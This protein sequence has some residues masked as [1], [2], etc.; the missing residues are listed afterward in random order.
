MM[1]KLDDSINP[2][3]ILQI[4]VSS[5]DVK[6]TLSLFQQF[7]DTAGINPFLQIVDPCQL[8][9][10]EA[11]WSGSSLFVIR[12]MNIYQQSGLN[13]LIWWYSEVCVAY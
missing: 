5:R 10:S 9:S 8:A 2:V 4:V 12:Y 7:L 11:S 1:Y 13:N 6:P 3:Q